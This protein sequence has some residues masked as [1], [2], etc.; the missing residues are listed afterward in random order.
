MNMNL[1]KITTLLNVIGFACVCIVIWF[2]SPFLM[3]S[4]HHIFSTVEARLVLISMFIIVLIVAIIISRIANY[5]DN[6]RFIKNFDNKMNIRTYIKNIPKTIKMLMAEL[7]ERGNYFDIRTAPWYLSIG[8]PQSGKSTLI[9]KS[10]VNFSKNVS[11][12]H[13]LLNSI[14]ACTWWLSDKAVVLDMARYENNQQ[15]SLNWDTEKNKELWA[16]FLKYLK[17]H[18]FLYR[19]YP[20]QGLIL[21]WP[22][23]YHIQHDKTHQ[24]EQKNVSNFRLNQI[25]TIIG[26]TYPIFL[27]ITKM[28]EIEGFIEFFSHCDDAEIEKALGFDLPYQEN[29]EVVEKLADEKFTAFVEFLKSKALS[30]VNQ[31]DDLETKKRIID[32]PNQLLIIKNFFIDSIKSTIWNNRK[33]N[34]LCGVYFTSVKQ[35]SEPY[36]LLDPVIYEKFGFEFTQNKFLAKNERVYFTRGLFN[37]ILEF[38]PNNQKQPLLLKLTKKAHSSLY[39]LGVAVFFFCC[40]AI[41]L[42]YFSNK[43]RFLLTINSMQHFVKEKQKIE[44]TNLT[45]TAPLPALTKLSDAYNILSEKIVLIDRLYSVGDLSK[46]EKSKKELQ[47]T[48]YRAIHVLFLPRLMDYF[49]Q[50]LIECEDTNELEELLIG[51]M[52]FGE[53]DRV[54]DEKIKI[55]L[56]KQWPKQ[57]DKK[58]I[59]ALNNIL[60]LLIASHIPDTKLDQEIILSSKQKIAKMPIGQRICN[61]IQATTNDQTIDINNLL[62]DDDFNTLFTIENNANII[63]IFYTKTGVDEF[64]NTQLPSIEE[65][66][67]SENW[68]IGLY[69]TD[70]LEEALDKGKNEAKNIYLRSYESYWQK[71]IENT[72]LLPTHSLAETI[73]QLKIINAPIMDYFSLIKNNSGAII[74][75][76]PNFLA[77][78]TFM[79]DPKNIET[80]TNN[81]KSVTEYLE[82][83]QLQPMT[84]EAA[85]NALKQRMLG[86][87]DNDPINALFLTVNTLPQPLQNWIIVMITESN[88]QLMA[89]AKHYINNVWESTVYNT[90]NEKLKYQYPLNPTSNTELALDQFSSFFGPNGTLSIFY[91]QYLQPFIDNSNTTWDWLSLNGVNFSEQSDSLYFFKNIHLIMNNFFNPT[92]G[93]PQLRIMVTPYVLDPKA[94]DAIFNLSNTS[95]VYRHG[96]VQSYEVNWPNKN[97]SL[98]TGD[99]AGIVMHDFAKNQ[100]SYTLIGPWAIFKFF[101]H[102]GLEQRTATGDALLTISLE[103]LR[104]SYIMNTP[105]PSSLLTLEPFSALNWNRKLFNENEQ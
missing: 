29:R 72:L 49:H 63:P 50:Q 58:T 98:S 97:N 26:E 41:T 32:F 88:Q 102:F 55:A 104:V 59:S 101:Q 1:F 48:L 7:K 74:K 91:T 8:M 33:K 67:I 37:K 80:L 69:T 73:K 51:Y 82:K 31:I 76:N 45:I 60:D 87:L 100:S 23:S 54:N 30:F 79:S 85:F 27:V 40:T 43:D 24:E 39:V 68:Y 3:I 99:S 95:I 75:N 56:E 84:D 4:G 81:L 13:E 10:Q 94:V 44:K 64:F 17:R 78:N 20:M 62:R 22:V 47:K 89:L 70:S 71:L 61:T 105:G 36:T 16:G 14:G 66:A 46:Q 57:Y 19:E 35:T 38:K 96:P 34:N 92:S 5:Y 77:I 25:D 12:T 6:K 83:I 18:Y 42:H 11:K 53:Y 52:A 90:Y 86:K 65:K 93:N 9:S 103:N 2:A 15:D 28:D 21:T